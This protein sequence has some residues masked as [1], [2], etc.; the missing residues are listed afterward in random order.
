[1]ASLSVLLAS[2]G[3]Y[4][5]TESGKIYDIQ[6]KSQTSLGNISPSLVFKNN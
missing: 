6:Q 4:V 3:A 1:M 2:I 5:K